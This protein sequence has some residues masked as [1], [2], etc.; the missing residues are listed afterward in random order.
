MQRDDILRV[1]AAHPYNC[2]C[3]FRG[4]RSS[5]SRKD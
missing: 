2:I 1:L 3:A 5:T 4:S